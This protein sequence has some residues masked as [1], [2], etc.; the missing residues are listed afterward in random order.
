MQRPLTNGYIRGA[1]HFQEAVEVVPNPWDPV[2]DLNQLCVAC[3]AA[4]FHLNQF[5]SEE[6]TKEAFHWLH[7]VGTEHPPDPKRLQERQNIKCSH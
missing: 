7:V 5:P 3:S 2:N 6:A 1:V 4:N